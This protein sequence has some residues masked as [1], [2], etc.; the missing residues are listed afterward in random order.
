[1]TA[2]LRAARRIVSFSIVLSSIAASLV[3]AQDQKT[4]RVYSYIPQRFEDLQVVFDGSLG[5]MG[6]NS[7]WWSSVTRNT[8]PRSQ[9]DE[10]QGEWRFGSRS[11]LTYLNR[12]A[13]RLYQLTLDLQ[14]SV[15]GTN[16]DRNQQYGHAT[17]SE[18]RFLTHEEAARREF[19]L[20][21]LFAG[22][23]Q[24]YL[25]A[26]MS[27]Q[28]DLYLRG[29]YYELS[30]GTDDQSRVE[31]HSFADSTYQSE[32]AYSRSQH[33]DSKMYAIDG[34]ITAGWGRR[35]EGMYAATALNMV[36]ELRENNVI[37]REPTEEQLS[38]LTDLVYR[39]RQTSSSDKR[40]FRIESL[41]GILDYLASEGIIGERLP[42]QH[43]LIEDVW[44]YFPRD[45]R[46]FGWQAR[47]GVGYYHDWSMSQG[48]Q[49]V[50]SFDR[51]F[52]FWEGAMPGGDTVRNDSSA[53]YRYYHNSQEN[54][55]SYLVAEVE[56]SKPIGLD[57]QM[58]ISG[59]GK[60]YIY[61]P[62]QDPRRSLS[63]HFVL[64]AGASLKWLLDG[65][66]EWIVGGAYRFNSI[67]T[68]YRVSAYYLPF[69]L[70]QITESD[71]Y[72]FQVSSDF[73][74]RISVPT[75]LFIG[76]TVSTLHSTNSEEWG[77]ESD[78]GESDFTTYQLSASIRHFLF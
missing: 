1:M 61:E 46:Y 20:A 43:L 27:L 47:S 34:V 62:Q 68:T 63:D 7:D 53:S 5:I 21:G 13:D 66:T 36:R 72:E 8:E 28:A 73:V 67:T 37:E 39:Y 31:T 23:F 48:D 76:G 55:R 58:E 14:G 60:Y 42:Y 22:R 35:Y 2:F 71:E 16:R 44:D 11:R 40:L 32:S 45:M 50:Y 41:N 30:K 77:I 25:V 64:A 38:E 57:W 29:N 26:D 51:V 10:S 19:R 78:Y 4:F 18:Y 52:R 17:G 12:T 6:D 15:F 24:Q 75:S 56:W 49:R 70:D 3:S 54:V 69:D 59:E 65:R 74:Y 33:H 9:T